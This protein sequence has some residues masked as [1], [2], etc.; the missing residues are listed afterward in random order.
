MET[1]EQVTQTE[2]E[3]ECDSLMRWLRLTGYG[4]DDLARTLGMRPNTLRVALTRRR[5]AGDFRWRF[6]RHFGANV[7]SVVLSTPEA[8]DAAESGEAAP[9]VQ[10]E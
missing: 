1:Q 6:L 4:I 5:L 7:A 2:N 3:R 9:V 8:L 10:V